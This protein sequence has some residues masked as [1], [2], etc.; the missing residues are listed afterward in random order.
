MRVLAGAVLSGA[1]LNA[2]PA[3]AADPRKNEPMSLPH[4][5]SESTL[6]NLGAIAVS[7]RTDN[8][9][10]GAV[11]PAPPLGFAA[12]PR[13]GTF[14]VTGSARAMLSLTLNLGALLPDGSAHIPIP[15]K[16]FSEASKAS[17]SLEPGGKLNL[18]I[19]TFFGIGSSGGGAA[20]GRSGS[21]H[22][23][24]N[25]L[26]PWKHATIGWHFQF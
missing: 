7:M 10:L 3:K 17:L 13:D 20:A 2:A 1:L 21:F 11:E 6:I 24:V 19:N 12:S 4:R 9:V 18:A 22:V 23:N 26:H 25:P 16:T 5:A 14:T 8:I 15:M